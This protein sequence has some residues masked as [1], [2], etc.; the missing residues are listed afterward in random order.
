MALFDTNKLVDEVIMGL[1]CNILPTV[2]VVYLVAGGGVVF[3]VIGGT[4]VVC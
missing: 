2:G 3:L 1:A 4:S